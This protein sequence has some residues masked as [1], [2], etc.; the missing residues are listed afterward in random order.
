MPLGISFITFTLIAYL[1]DVYA[2]RYKLE[3]NISLLSGLVLF[4]PHL[5][6]GPIL[7]PSDLLPQL[8]RKN[9][10]LIVYFIFG[11]SIFTVGLFKKLVFADTLAPHVDAVFTDQQLN[12][13]KIDYVVAIYAFAIQIYCDFSGYTDMAIGCAI[14][15]GV[16]LP[17][18]FDRPY[19]SASIIEFW[20]K[21][22][23]T[24]SKWLKD[25]LYIPLGGGRVSYARQVVNL[26]ITM[27]LGGLW[28]GA[29]WNFILWGAAHGVGISFVHA[30]RRFSVFSRLFT[31]S[32]PTSIFLTLHFVVACWILF[33]APDLTVAWRV[34]SGPFYAEAGNFYERIREYFFPLLLMVI[35]LMTHRWDSHRNIRSLTQRL[36]KEVFWPL[37]FVI[38]LIAL[39]ISDGNTAK[40]IYF[41]F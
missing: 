13:T 7:R 37:V 31:L 21:W 19:T 14:V 33:R 16:K 5:I 17:N 11:L 12:L 9:R 28:H 26:L 10:K 1:V 6:A 24:L 8:Q 39:V 25:Y 40:F 23:I 36:P 35:F 18:N 20:T 34:A 41:D 15:L 3:K 2:G 38:W 22:H 4:F 30:I 29:N 32:K 27:V